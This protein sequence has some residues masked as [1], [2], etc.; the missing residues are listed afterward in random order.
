MSDLLNEMQSV[1]NMIQKSR[2]YSYEPP[3]TTAFQKILDTSVE[4]ISTKKK[5]E[6]VSP[7]FMNILKECHP[8]VFFPKDTQGKEYPDPYHGELDVPFPIM[9]IEVL[10]QAISV[11][12]PN[13]PI[14]QMV[15]VSCIIIH[16]VKPREYEFYAYFQRNNEVNGEVKRQF[17]LIG[18][19][20]QND[21][22]YD[23]FK[24]FVG[25]Y[26]ERLHKEKVGV[27]GRSQSIKYKEH[28]VKKFMRPK[29]ITYVSPVKY[30]SETENEVHRNIVWSHR[31]EVRGHWRKTSSIG[32]DREGNYCIEGYTWVVPSIKGP[33]NSP[34]IKKSRI[35]KEDSN[36]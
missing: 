35:L 32:K 14:D 34:L 4:A 24:S 5:Y 23:I 25:E 29:N 19:L 2:K 33:Q 21:D 30:I 31:W 7:S 26:L 20:R 36:K 16:E 15:W 13:T 18:P 12:P 22:H 6:V 3:K 27:S 10:G 9:S 11:P 8:F 28:G 17:G 1:L